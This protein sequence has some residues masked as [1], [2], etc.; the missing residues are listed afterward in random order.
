[1]LTFAS[2]LV[3][4]SGPLPFFFAPVDFSLGYGYDGLEQVVL[5]ADF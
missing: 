1:M 2:F 4:F 3:R 5:A